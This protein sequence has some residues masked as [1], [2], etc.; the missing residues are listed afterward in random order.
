MRPRTFHLPRPWGEF[1]DPAL[2]FGAVAG[3]PLGS[4]PSALVQA[5]AHFSRVFLPG[6]SRLSIQISLLMYSLQNYQS[7]LCIIE[8]QHL[9]LLKNL[10]WFHV[11][12]EKIFNSLI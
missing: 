3:L 11:A 8:I 7:D 4:T 12:F 10:R 6:I 9:Y 5:R 2:Y 1:L